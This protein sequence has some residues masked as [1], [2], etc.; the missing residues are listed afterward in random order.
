MRKCK[1]S[2]V[3]ETEKVRVDDE[4]QKNM[5]ELQHVHQVIKILKEGKKDLKN[6]R[7]TV[8]FL[9]QGVKTQIEENKKKLGTPA[10]YDR[11]RKQLKRENVKQDLETRKT[12]YEELLNNTDKLVET[13]DEMIIA[14]TKLEKD[15][16][17][18]NN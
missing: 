12:K 4:L 18:I 2:T 13:T 16:E 1:K 10:A 3:L 11:E 9:L 8:N 14:M 7:E 6:Q 15:I 17:Q 5:G